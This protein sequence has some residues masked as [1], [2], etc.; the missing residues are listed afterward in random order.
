MS[1]LICRDVP[2][3]PAVLLAVGLEVSH[4]HDEVQVELVSL[5]VFVEATDRLQATLR[6]QA[7]TVPE[8]AEGI[9]AVFVAVVR[10]DRHEHGG[11][12]AADHVDQPLVE[13]VDQLRGR[14][15]DLQLAQDLDQVLAAFAPEQELLVRR[16][17]LGHEVVQVHTQQSELHQHQRRDADLTAAN[18]RGAG[19]PEVLGLPSEDREPRDQPI[20]HLT[21]CCGFVLLPLHA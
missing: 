7:D 16:R 19:T 18:T 3:Q 15:V 12:L 20:V 2:N 8:R 1:E 14:D 6:D 21:G 5:G 9:L 11:V 17:N 4:G 10:A 13:R